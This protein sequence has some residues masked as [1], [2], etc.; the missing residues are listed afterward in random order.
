MEVRSLKKKSINFKNFFSII[1]GSIRIKLILCF[2]V[3]VLFIVIL[4]LGAYKSSSK[5]ITK[6]FTNATVSSI[7]KT[8]EYYDLILKNI[9]DKAVSFS[10]DA[11]IRDYYAGKYSKNALENGKAYKAAQ[12]SASIIATSDRYIENIFIVSG[13]GKPIIT[14]GKV[15]DK[16]DLFK[17]FAKTQEASLIDTNNN[18]NLWTGYHEFLDKQLEIPKD[19]YAIT[20]SKPLLN[21]TARQIGYLFVDVSMSVITDAMKTLELPENS[22]L[23]FITQDGK[24]ITPEGDTSEPIFTALTEYQKIQTSTEPNEHLSVNYEGEEHELIYSRIGNSGA[25]ICAMIPSS[26]LLEQSNSIKNLTFVLVV[27]AAVFAVLTGV[28]VAYGFG[29]AITEMIH[30]LSKATEGDL[31]ATVNHIRKDEF[32]VLSKSINQMIGSLNE[33]INKATKVGQTVSESSRNVSENSELLLEASKNISIAISEIQQGNVQQAEGTEQ[34]LRITD[35]L[36]NQ[37]NKVHEN[38]LAIEKISETT[39]NVVKDG[40][41]EMDQLTAVTDENVRVTNNTIRDIEEL[42][43]ESKVIT[44]IIAVINGIAGQTN[45]LSLNASIEAARAGD[46][47]RGFSVV[48]DEIRELS[49]K[50]VTAAREIEQI[51]K[52]IIAK[53]HAT[54][55]TVKQAES[56]SKTTEVRLNNVVQ[57]FNNINIHVDDLAGKMEMITDSIGE[58]NRSKVDTLNSIESISAVSEETT[59][60]SQEVDATA[61]QQLE[62]VTKLNEA[63]KAL[64]RDV[65]DLENAIEIFKI[66]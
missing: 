9:E 49:N 2:L 60:A 43:K 33:I 52:N 65:T 6:T 38:A 54:V 53:T 51:I 18:T 22:Y 45:L 16:V 34:C 3:P 42:E 21:V 66:K 64:G 35:E 50:S 55:N 58:I 48:A 20:L 15:D 5:A 17:E 32:G 27:M 40:I 29:K 62:V 23:A 10:V 37:I 47:G 28:L 14:Y 11:Q 19:K 30:T 44:E 13:S 24:E 61:Q 26:Y 59:A 41:E 1:T 7:E 12:S 36:S 8:G 39:K 25:V 56:I 31:T 57:L 63:A 4:G 46:A